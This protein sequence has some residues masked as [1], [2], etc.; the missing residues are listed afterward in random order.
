MGLVD[1]K[2]GFV[3]LAPSFPL[4][5]SFSDDSYFLAWLFRIGFGPLPALKIGMLKIVFG[6]LPALKI[7]M[8]KMIGVLGWMGWLYR[9]GMGWSFELLLSRGLAV[10]EIASVE[11]LWLS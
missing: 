7:G 1:S 4:V 3:S 8:L 2:F 5:V 9:L 6:P 11:W 10:D